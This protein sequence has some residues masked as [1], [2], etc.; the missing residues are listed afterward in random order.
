MDPRESTDFIHNECKLMKLHYRRQLHFA[1]F[2]F[3]SM[4]NLAP[5]YLSN[6]LIAQ[7]QEGT[8]RSLILYLPASFTMVCPIVS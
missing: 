7:Q 4:K 1:L 2:V 6:K 3:K 8:Y 5:E